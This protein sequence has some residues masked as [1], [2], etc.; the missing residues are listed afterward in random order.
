VGPATQH[1]ATHQTAT[2]Q[3]ATHRPPPTRPPLARPVQGRW[4]AGVCAGVAAHLGVP[5]AQVRLVMALLLVTGPGLP[6]YLFLWALAPQQLT[7]DLP[8]GDPRATRV[9]AAVVGG[10]WAAVVAVGGLV[11]LV[12]AAVGLQ[13]AGID[14]RA[15]VLVPLLVIAAGAIVAWSNLDE[16]GRDD[17]LGSGAAGRA[18]GWIRVALGLGLVVVGIL[19]L[20]L[21]RQ[22]LSAVWDAL[23]A[24]AAVLCGAV[25]VAA[26]W[27]VRLWRG[28]RREQVA[29][30][31]A[32]ERADIAA[33]LHD[34]VLQTL[35]L[36]QRRAGD[37][38]AVAQLARAQEREL[39]A[40]LYAPPPGQEQTL[41][42]AVTAAAHEVEDLHGCRSS[43][44]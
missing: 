34:S 17:W 37:P 2:H 43:S 42:A 25:I 14:V 41:A 35:T 8:P 9:A 13:Q 12:G 1:T 39:R 22:P 19:V 31:R 11:V 3:T 20:A 6:V 15:P 38:V 29:A 28:M 40:W 10:P 33:H 36:I 4:L 21:R 16:A 7:P 26:P 24:T 23:L 18:H 32:T 30:A 27:V 5:V 44:W